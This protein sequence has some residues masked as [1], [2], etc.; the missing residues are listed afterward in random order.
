MVTTVSLAASIGARL[1]DIL[2]FGNDKDFASDCLKNEDNI[3]VLQGN[4]VLDRSRNGMWAAQGTGC[5][6]YI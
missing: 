3:A 5:L 1:D 4:G 6:A 2:L